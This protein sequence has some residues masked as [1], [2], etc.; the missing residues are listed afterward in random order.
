MRGES[1]SRIEVSG[2]TQHG[3]WLLLDDQEL[4]LSFTEFPWFKTAPVDAVFHV[5]RLH[6]HHLHWPDLDVD[7]DVRSIQ[8]P[9]DFPLIAQPAH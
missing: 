9:E 6:G 7:L 3:F 8:H 1:V 4:F 5:E 2:I